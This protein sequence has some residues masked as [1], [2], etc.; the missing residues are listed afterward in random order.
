L[1]ELP[2]LFEPLLLVELPLLFEPLLLVE[3]PLAF[4]PVLLVE[5]PVLP[6]LPDF[7]DVLPSPVLTTATST[8]VVCVV[9]PSEPVA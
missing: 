5:L 4:E 3:L 9:L 8:E 6:V 2:L 1:V 7:V